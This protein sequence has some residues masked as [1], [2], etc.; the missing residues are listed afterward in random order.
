[1]PHSHV[2]TALVQAAATLPDTIVTIPKRDLFD[3]T[4][5]TLQIV[6]LLLA[7]GLL[8]A[9]ILLLLSLRNAVQKVN[10]TIEKLAAETRPLIQRATGIVDD[11]KEVVAMV[12]TDV[13]RVTD[14][15]SLVSDQ[16]IDAAETTSRRVDEVNAVLDVLQNELESSAIG[17]VAAVRGVRVGARTLSDNLRSRDRRD[18]R[19]G[20]LPS[21]GAALGTGDFDDDF[22]EFEDDDADFAANTFVDDPFEFDEA[23][24]GG[25]ARNGRPSSGPRPA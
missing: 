3:W 10:T 16:L 1:M 7:I 18:R 12:R 4:S 6:V 15:A 5:G 9:M 14:A 23:D 11:A 17:T 22:D 19:A 2:L 8:V 24:D 20:D 13:E 21:D 25:D